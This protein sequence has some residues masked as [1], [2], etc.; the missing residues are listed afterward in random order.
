MPQSRGMALIAVLW[1]VAAMGLIISGVVRTVRA[2][3]QTVGLQ[4]QSL[5]A[6][7]KADAAILLALQN[8]HA[9]QKPLPNTLQTLPVEFEGV[10]YQ[11]QLVP[12]NGLIDINK[13]PVALLADLYQ[14]AGGADPQVA[15]ALAAATLATRQLKNAKT[16]EQGFDAAADLM[17]VPG[18]TYDIY[19]K[20]HTLVTADVKSGS[21]RV[22]PLASPPSVLLVLAAGDGARANQF[23]SQRNATPN[24]VD[25]TFFKP[26][27]IDMSASNSLKLQVSVT[28]PDNATLQRA[29]RLYWAPDPRSGL[30]WRVLGV[31]QAVLPPSHV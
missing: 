18:I 6:S 30:P 2:E 23:L 20:V 9:Q 22:N 17:R 1:L 24:T 21:G 25:S 19:D 29:W 15:Q 28:L 4:R 13:A 5:V 8:L 11:V 12:L 31:Q 27:S 3:A 26:D 16:I 7:A 14:Y 10:I